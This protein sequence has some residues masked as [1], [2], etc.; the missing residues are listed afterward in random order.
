MGIEADGLAI[1]VVMSGKSGLH[2]VKRGTVIHSSG[3][4][5]V[6]TKS[7]DLDTSL[8]F[9]DDRRTYSQGSIK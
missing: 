3:T 2:V 1:P 4:V 9:R 8:C 6:I 7:R 5:G